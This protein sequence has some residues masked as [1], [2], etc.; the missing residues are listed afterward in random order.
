[1]AEQTAVLEIV[2]TTSDLLARLTYKYGQLIFVKELP[3][4]SPLR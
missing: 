1:M 2:S 3:K 4:I